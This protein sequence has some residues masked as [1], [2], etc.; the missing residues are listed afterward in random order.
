MYKKIF[1]IIFLLIIVYPSSIFALEI[2]KNSESAILYEPST[3]KVLYEKNSNEKLAPASM[4]KIM[5]ML[6]LM[7]AVDNE[8]VSLDEEVLISK[9]ASSMGGTQIFIEEGTKVK[10][11]DLLK[12]IGIASANDVVVIKKQSQVIGE[13]ITI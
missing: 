9:K 8:K 1:L 4:T 11:I 2:V 7:E 3:K 10:V 13:E 12:G 5:T 6:L